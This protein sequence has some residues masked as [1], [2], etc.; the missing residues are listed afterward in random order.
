VKRVLSL[1]LAGFDRAVA[2]IALVLLAALLVVVS[3]GVVT[4]ADGDPLLWT[5]EVSRFLMVWLACAGW[6]LASRHRAH[7]RIRYFADKLPVQVRRGVDLVLHAA[8]AVF[9]L[10]VAWH[11]WT[12]V[13][14]N[15]DLEA[16]T[17][18][19]AMAVMYAPIV[20]AGAVTA[21]QAL[22]EAIETV[23]LLGR[24]A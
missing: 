2:F 6:L 13:T 8:V 20:V 19:V 21:A 12:L 10:L 16:T 3:L 18:P 9:G 4:R 14:R 5:D 1:A 17:V 15:L 24:R 22:G 11:G 7:V 23:V